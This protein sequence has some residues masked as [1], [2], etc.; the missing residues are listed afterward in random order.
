MP[1]TLIAIID[2]DLRCPLLAQSRHRLVHCTCPLSGAKQTLRGRG[3]DCKQSLLDDGTEIET[4][5]NGYNSEVV[6]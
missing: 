1:L 4:L 5:L 3:H 6:A 2:R